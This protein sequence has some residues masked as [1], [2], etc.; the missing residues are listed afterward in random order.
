MS[1]LATEL[2]RLYGLASDLRAER[3]EGQVRALVLELA[4]PSDWAA[5][6]AVW[7]GVQVDLEL[8][9]PAIAANGVDGLQLWFALAEPVPIAQGRAFL[10]GLRVRYLGGVSIARVGMVLVDQAGALQSNA[11]SLPVPAL[12][13][14]GN[15]FAFLAP[16]LVAIFAD[17]PWLDREPSAQAQASV[18][19]GLQCIKPD[20][21]QS[22]LQQLGP[23]M[24]KPRGSAAVNAIASTQVG[25]PLQPGEALQPR[26]F[27][28]DV[29][30]DAS[31]ELHLRIEA[32]RALLPYC[33]G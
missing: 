14:H 11:P 7:R 19:A 2:D 22:V 4:R 32:A 6:S 9:A 5:L 16:D 33:E 26:R 13:P 30:N 21:F 8:P 25:A 3:A 20:A 31:V 1:A 29:M 28:L 10:D 12:Q 23:S 24:Q 17:E 27:L 18:L 15:W